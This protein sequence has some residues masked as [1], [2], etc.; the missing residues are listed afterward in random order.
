MNTPKPLDSSGLS[1]AELQ[2]Y[3]MLS[4][5]EQAQYKALATQ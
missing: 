1:G 2:A 4:P 3:N 5:Q